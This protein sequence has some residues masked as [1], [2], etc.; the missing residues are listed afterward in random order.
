MNK[1]QLSAGILLYITQS[2]L[3]TYV[4][5]P[6]DF[7]DENFFYAFVGSLALNYYIVAFLF[8]WR[9]PTITLTLAR[10]AHDLQRFLLFVFF[11]FL[12]VSIYHSKAGDI[13]IGGC[14]AELP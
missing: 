6:D 5:G 3:S 9:M 10:G 14:D 12:W 8:G 7:S 1:Y 2:T 4:L 13:A 11:C